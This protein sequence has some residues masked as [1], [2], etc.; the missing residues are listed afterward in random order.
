[1]MKPLKIGVFGLGTVGGGLLEM[2]LGKGPLSKVVEITGVS[3]R[4]KNRP[5]PV[6]ISHIKWFD[7]GI[8]LAKDENIEV[9]VELVGGADGAAF[10]AVRAALAAKKHVVTANK[11]MLSAHGI[12]LQELAKANNVEIRYEAAVAGGIPIV[13]ALREGMAANEIHTIMGVMNGTSNYILTEMAKTGR[14]FEDVLKDAQGL[15]LAE[16]DPTLDINGGDAGHKLALLSALAFS[17]APNF[18]AIEL[19]GIETIEPVDLESAKFLGFAVKLIAAASV[20]N[21]CLRQSVRPTLVANA[22]PIAQ[23]DG[24]TNAILVEASPVGTLTFIGAGAGAGATASAVAA[25]LVDLSYG[26]S[27]PIFSGPFI[28]RQELAIAPKQSLESKF[29]VRFRVAD[30]PGVIAKISDTLARHQVS[31]ESFL[32]KPPSV[33]DNVAIVL[34]TQKCLESILIDAMNELSKYDEF[35]EKPL[36]MPIFH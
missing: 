27:R 31:I 1:M 22:N 3:A 12:E 21:N 13:K 29:Y 26:D 18:D 2:A 11:A 35:V 15:G 8:S 25:D 17:G 16:A 32:Q 24:A 10:D 34:T 5:R 6:D 7:D 9:F 23:I 19:A 20:E 36:I 4:T 28:T 14:A 30:K 33:P